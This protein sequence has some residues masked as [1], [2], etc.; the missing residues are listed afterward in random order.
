VS[1]DLRVTTLPTPAP[2]RLVNHSLPQQASPYPCAVL[3]IIR[4][5]GVVSLAAALC[6]CSHHDSSTALTSVNV[7]V[8]GCAPSGVPL[9]PVASPPPTPDKAYPP[10]SKD[11]LHDGYAVGRDQWGAILSDEC[12]RLP[13]NIEITGLCS[14]LYDRLPATGPALDPRSRWITGCVKGVTDGY[15]TYH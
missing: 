4:F 13:A 5:A 14:D 8:G 6:S 7:G 15:H 10:S 9:S 2:P 3:S 11:D 12:A 1:D